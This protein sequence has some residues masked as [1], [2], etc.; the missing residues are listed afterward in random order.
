MK[1]AAFYHGPNR[2]TRY[3]EAFRTGCHRHGIECPV[4]P[5]GKRTTA[6]LIWLYGLGPAAPAFDMH[7][8]AIRIVGDKG[9]FAGHQ[10]HG[11]Y[12]R[13]S[14]DAQQPDEHLKT[15]RHSQARWQAMGLNIEPV[16][17]RGDYVLICGAGEKQCWLQ[18]REY[19]S[20][21]REAYAKLQTITGRQIYVREKPGQRQI[22]GIPR[23][24]EMRAQDAIRG[25]W[26]VVCQTGNIG[27]DCILEGVPVIARG[28][29]GS[30]YYTN[31][32]SQ[33]ESIQPIPARERLDALANIA[34]L[35]WTLDEIESGAM[36]D[37]LKSGGTI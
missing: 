16:A 20:W 21:E 26:A 1:A 13:I 7:P 17:Q 34:H 29:P 12:L 14:V 32:L 31:D 33:I 2:I 24:A 23:L 4:I 37:S 5:V 10:Q 8:D 30:V 22:A 6:D 35:Q 18:G 36:L 9:Y 25:A 3:A 28:G 11:K 27:A 15:S 19:G